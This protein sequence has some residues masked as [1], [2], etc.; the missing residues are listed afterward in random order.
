[1]VAEVFFKK[2]SIWKERVSIWMCKG[3]E[4]EE[5]FRN[6]GL[7]KKRI[8]RYHSF[9]YYNPLPWNPRKKILPNVCFQRQ[10][11][12]T[13]LIIRDHKQHWRNNGLCIKGN[14]ILSYNFVAK[15][16]KIKITKNNWGNW[17]LS[18]IEFSLRR[19]VK[20]RF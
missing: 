17:K 2:C 19:A 8:Y 15:S 7:E 14:G 16:R 10:F 18:G 6:R 11:P 12:C 5:P 1:M 3:C 9:L 4:K 20:P 13:I